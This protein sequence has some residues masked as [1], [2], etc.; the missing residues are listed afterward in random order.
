LL[1]HHFGRILVDAIVNII[2][3]FFSYRC[4]EGGVYVLKGRK[5]KEKE[6]DI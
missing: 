6:K 4:W 3:L 2:P 1:S 5:E